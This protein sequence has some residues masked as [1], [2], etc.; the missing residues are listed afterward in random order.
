MHGRNKE[1][2]FSIPVINT[3]DW[4]IYLT[5]NGNLHKK[6]RADVERDKKTIA[7]IPDYQFKQ[8]NDNSTI[9]E[10]SSRLKI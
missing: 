3:R 7:F 1:E 9:I 8:L 6:I 4:M 5:A 10:I 2:T